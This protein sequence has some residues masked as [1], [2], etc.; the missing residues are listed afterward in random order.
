MDIKVRMPSFKKMLELFLMLHVIDFIITSIAI[1]MIGCFSERNIFIANIVMSSPWR[2][3]LLFVLST[4][5]IA[6]IFMSL[7]RL[8]RKIPVLN[9]LR[10][11]A[12]MVV[13]GK[14]IVVINNIFNVLIYFFKLATL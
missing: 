11:L 6:T 1:H 9:Y 3:M 10:V 13:I 12:L 4:I 7:E 5:Y 2:F 8:S 14:I